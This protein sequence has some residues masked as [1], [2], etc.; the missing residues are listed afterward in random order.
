MHYVITH[1]IWNKLVNP[2]CQKLPNAIPRQIF[3][4]YG[5]CCYVKYW[6]G[7]IQYWFFLE[8][9]LH[10]LISRESEEIGFLELLLY[11]K[12]FSAIWHKQ[13]WNITSNGIILGWTCFLDRHHN[14]CYTITSQS[15]QWLSPTWRGGYGKYE[16]CLLQNYWSLG[17]LPFQSSQDS[18]YQN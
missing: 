3:W 11:S 14:S 6:T 7:R 12:K 9:G 10:Y 5:M 2:D 15:L 17:K 4:A 13:N 16:Y 8:I 1:C 18:S